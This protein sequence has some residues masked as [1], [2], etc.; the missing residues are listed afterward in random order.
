[1]PVLAQESIQQADTAGQEVNQKIDE[2]VI[3]DNQAIKAEASAQAK[4]ANLAVSRG[5]YGSRASLRQQKVATIIDLKHQED[6][7]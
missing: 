7:N 2:A 3:A 1:M 5:D 6:C 4:P